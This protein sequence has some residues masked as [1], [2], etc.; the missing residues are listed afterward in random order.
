MEG[1]SSTLCDGYTIHIVQFRT[2]PKDRIH[3][4]SS[5]SVASILRVGIQTKVLYFQESTKAPGRGK[6]YRSSQTGA[7]II[8]QNFE[9]VLAVI[10][11]LAGDT[12]F[13]TKITKSR[14]NTF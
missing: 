14:G 2:W 3:F 13:A 11:M 6:R 4:M 1:A 7:L 9:A 10:V 12:I 8:P 5:H